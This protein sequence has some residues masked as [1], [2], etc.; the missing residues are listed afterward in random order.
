MAELGVRANVMGPQPIARRKELPLGMLEA[1]DRVV[2]QF[3]QGDGD[4]LAAMSVQEVTGAVRALAAGINP[5]I[6]TRH[7]MVAVA[8]VI[9]HYYVKARMFGDG[10][11]PFTLQFRLGN[12]DGRWL[13]WEVLNLTGRRAAWT[14]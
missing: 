9:H 5:G 10:A 13:L 2:A 8:R 4:A 3:A 6:Y 14:R 11:D 12:K 1:A 7:E